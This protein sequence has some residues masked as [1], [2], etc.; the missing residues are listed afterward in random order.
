[1]TVSME[2][3]PPAFGDGKVRLVQSGQRHQTG[4]GDVLPGVLVGL[5]NVD[6][7]GALI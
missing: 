6:E 1:M 7:K 5:A 2:D 4:A 3:H